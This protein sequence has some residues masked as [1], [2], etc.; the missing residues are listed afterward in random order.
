MAGIARKPQPLALHYDLPEHA[1]RRLCEIRDVLWQL[2][3][4][5]A[6]ADTKTRPLKVDA[7]PVFACF[8]KHADE[9]AAVVDSCELRPPG[10]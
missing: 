6:S 8:A 1:Y 2:A 4:L 10:N 5:A 7:R 3:D 9:L